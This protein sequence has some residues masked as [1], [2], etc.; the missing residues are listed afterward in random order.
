V[1]TYPPSGPSASP[2][3]TATWLSLSPSS[4]LRRRMSCTT[5]PGSSS[6]WLGQR[7]SDE[8]HV[9]VEE[10]PVITGNTSRE[11]LRTCPRW[12][13]YQ[14]GDVL[15]NERKTSFRSVPARQCRPRHHMLMCWRSPALRWSRR[16][17]NVALNL[18]DLEWILAP[19]PPAWPSSAA[20]E[21][22]RRG[23]PDGAGHMSPLRNVVLDSPS[24]VHLPPDHHAFPVVAWKL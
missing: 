2:K 19:P 1:D 21:L 13:V 15:V 11:Y 18:A 14:S 12:S 7:W 22:P 20:A 6:A 3:S 10:I 4:Q 17:R 5:S 23:S 16:L 9:R 24:F 8:H